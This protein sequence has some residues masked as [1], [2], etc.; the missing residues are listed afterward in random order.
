MKII[1]LMLIRWK[2][3][4]D[5]ISAVEIKLM[6]W[7]NYHDKDAAFQALCNYLGYLN[8]VDPQKNRPI[9]LSYEYDIDWQEAYE[10]LRASR[11]QVGMRKK[12]ESKPKTNEGQKAIQKQ[13]TGDEISVVTQDLNVTDE[14]QDNQLNIFNCYDVTDKIQGRY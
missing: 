10:M 2:V 3:D 4:Q 5:D 8:R 9:N 7:R 1:D 12:N 6:Y 14:K 13:K 11:Y